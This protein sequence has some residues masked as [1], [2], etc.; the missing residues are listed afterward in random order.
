MDELKDNSDLLIY[1]APDGQIKIDVRLEDETFWL[2][3]EH[4]A[5]LF[6]YTKPIFI[7]W[8][9]LSTIKLSASLF[10]GLATRLK[11]LPPTLAIGHHH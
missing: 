9:Y 1:P 6:D 7:L 11:P 8:L 3:Q 4:M 5:Q 2:T 10:D